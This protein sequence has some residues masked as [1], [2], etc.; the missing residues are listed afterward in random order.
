MPL[1]VGGSVISK[2]MGDFY[3]RLSVAGSYI[4]N[5]LVLYLDA[6]VPESY[7]GSGTSWFDYSGNGNTGT[8]TNG[9]IFNSGNGGSIVFDGVN[10]R[11]NLGFSSTLD[12]TSSMTIEGFIYPTAYKVGGGG[13]G[14]LITKVASY[15]TELD[16]NGKIRAYY[17]GLNSPGY[18]NSNA[19]VPLNTWTYYAVVRN[20]STDSI[21]FYINGV[22]DRTISSITGNITVQQSFPVTLGSYNGSGYEYTGR[23]ATGKIYNRALSAAEIQQNFNATR[24]RFGI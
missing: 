24:N 10:D 2:E 21:I 18:H 6:G 13:G 14:M 3:S 22:L 7:P 23:I 12:I 17:Y 11:I 20:V 9:P 4:T 19:T 8:L 1:N 5:G 15:Y 16:S